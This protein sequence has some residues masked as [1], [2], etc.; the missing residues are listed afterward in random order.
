MVCFNYGHKFFLIAGLI[1][2]CPIHDC[3]LIILQNVLDTLHNNFW[4]YST[5]I[6]LIS[7]LQFPTRPG[8]PTKSL[9]CVFLEVIN[10]QF[11][12]LW[13]MGLSLSV[14]PKKISVKGWESGIL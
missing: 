10:L 8:L 7:P 1:L 9:E 12:K 13:G 3:M 5:Q 2:F 4:A 6:T 11:D 14:N